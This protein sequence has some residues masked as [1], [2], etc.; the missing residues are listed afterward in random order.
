MKL[1]SSFSLS[2]K[3]HRA[4]LVARSPF[5]YRQVYLKR[6]KNKLLHEFCKLSLPIK[7]DHD[8]LEAVISYMYTD[9]LTDI[10]D[11]K[12]ES[13]TELLTLFEMKDALEKFTNE[14]KSKQV[15]IDTHLINSNIKVEPI[16]DNLSVMVMQLNE[17]E[18]TPVVE[19]T[20]RRPE[21]EKKKR[22]RVTDTSEGGEEYSKGK[23]KVSVQKIVDSTL[24]PFLE[25]FNDLFK[26]HSTT[27]QIAQVSQHLVTLWHTDILLTKMFEQ[28]DLTSFFSDVMGKILEKNAIQI[29]AKNNSSSTDLETFKVET[30]YTQ[31]GLPTIDDA[32]TKPYMYTGIDGLIE[33]TRAVVV[34]G[35]L[36]NFIDVKHGPKFVHLIALYRYIVIIENR[37]VITT[38]KE[39][40]TD[41]D[42]IP[43]LIEGSVIET[44]AGDQ[45]SNLDTLVKEISQDEHNFNATSAHIA[46][47][48]QVSL[49]MKRKIVSDL[50]LY[51]NPSFHEE[52]IMHIIVDQMNPQN[53]LPFT[54]GIFL[55]KGCNFCRK[56]E[57]K[58]EDL[59]IPITPDNPVCPDRK[60]IKK[61]LQ[62]DICNKQMSTS[63]SLARHK[64]GVHDIDTGDVSGVFICSHCGD[65]FSKKWKLNIHEREHEDKKLLLTCKY[66]KKKIRGSI[67]LKKHIAKVH[68]AIPQFSCE[69]CSKV[70]KRKETLSV[71]RRIHTGEKP[72]IC[73]ECDYASE[74]K[75]N[76]KAHITRRHRAQTLS[77]NNSS[78]LQHNIIKHSK[79]FIKNQTVRHIVDSPLHQQT[80][81][82]GQARHALSNQ[83]QSVI[84]EEGVSNPA[85]DDQVMA[86][87]IVA[88]S[89]SDGSFIIT[90]GKESVSSGVQ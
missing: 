3:A 64:Y 36:M 45:S 24:I 79:H 57:C 26:P 16:D 75:G 27:F 46:L 7:V 10:L 41:K 18:S 88:H 86:A 12:A 66:C 32:Y 72:F 47:F 62:C 90:S 80:V 73:C 17:T 13:V 14:I 51:V 60:C 6:K 35:E 53:I 84:N 44:T 29:K 59:S 89:F 23:F 34:D 9:C 8:I 5:F 56:K 85:V 33:P 37:D 22:K 83:S 21:V 19:V 31:T 42:L 38:K 43:S 71:H 65:T 63:K 50:E 68:E 39:N 55:A 87:T 69:Y 28:K 11:K 20:E 74:T 2:C 77:F 78:S 30:Y 76:L 15:E 4:V 40:N 25:K 67:A 70:F 82:D 49:D 61:N 54:V 52:F 81:M 1:G 48:Q 58:S